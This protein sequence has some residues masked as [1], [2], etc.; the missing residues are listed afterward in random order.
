M[1]RLTS[2]QRTSLGNAWATENG[3]FRAA[4]RA[5]DHASAWRHLERAHIISQPLAARHV[6]THLTMLRVALAN[7]DVREAVGQL[8]RVVVA[9]PG[10]LTGRYPAGN[11]GGTNVGAFRPMQIPGDLRPIL[12]SEA[13]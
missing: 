13:P 6:R 11:T 9:G 2:R 3:A 1:N 4:R 5:G 12:G 8:F 7:A 10:S